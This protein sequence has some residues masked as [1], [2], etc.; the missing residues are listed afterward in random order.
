MTCPV[1]GGVHVR[2]VGIPS[3]RTLVRCAGCR[4]LFDSEPAAGAPPRPRLSDDE[5]RREERVSVRRAPG[6]ARVL[7]AV[8]PPGRLLD[9]GAG[10][11]ELL[12]LAR[13]AGWQAVGVDVDPAV[14]AYARA[15]GLDVR[16]GDLP[17]LELT[18]ASFDLVT[19]WNVIDFVSDPIGLLRECRRVLAPGGRVFV[20]TPN[21]PV[22]RAGARL[23][24]A[25]SKRGRGR[26]AGDGPSW[27]GVF[28]ASNFG[29]RTLRV[30]L[31]RAGFRDVDVRNSPPVGGDP[32]LGLGRAGER[33]LDLGKRAVF[34][35]VQG[36]ARA[37][38]GRCLLGPSIEAWGRNAA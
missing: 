12:A 32:Y 15:R 37:S 29:A 19:L 27:F 35:V 26:L 13:E 8:R 21:T 31:D 11:G 3:G 34:G 2:A 33:A 14:V 4:L 10:I 16:L 17:T 7:Y 6:F 36:V 5:R 24:R 20:R 18:A 38:A 30:A 22:Q 23:T 25:L 28:H 9:V 1:C